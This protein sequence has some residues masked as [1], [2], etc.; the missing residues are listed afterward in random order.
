MRPGR[1]LCMPPQQILVLSSG[2]AYGG[3]CDWIY[4]VVTSQYDVILAL[5]W[6]SL[7]AQRA[8]YSTRTLLTRYCSLQCVTAIHK[9]ISAPSSETGAKNSTRR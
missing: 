6:R 5:V 9:L 2:V 8:Y 1:L 4:A 3:Q 7:L